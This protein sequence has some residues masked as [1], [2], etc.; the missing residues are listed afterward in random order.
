MLRT[1]LRRVRRR[2]GLTQPPPPKPEAHGPRER[3]ES[4]PRLRDAPRR[5]RPARRAGARAPRT[6]S[7]SVPRS[8]ARPGGSDS[9]SSIP[10]S[11]SHPSSARSCTSST[12]SGGRGPTTELIALV[13]PLLPA[14]RGHAHRRE[15]ARSTCPAHGRRRWSRWPHPRRARSSC[16][17]TRSSATSPV[18]ATRTAAASIDE[19]EVEGERRA[20]GD[21]MRVVTDAIARG[22]YATQIEWLA[23]GVPA[24]AAAHPPVRALRERRRR[25]A[26]TYVRVPGPRA[27]STAGRGAGAASQHGQA[28]EARRP[29]PAPRSAA[30]LLPTGGRTAARPDDGPRPVAL[31]ELRRPGLTAG[32]PG[33]RTGPDRRVRP[34]RCDATESRLL[35]DVGAVRD[36]TAEE[37]QC[38]DREDGDECQDERVLG[39]C[40]TL[41]ATDRWF[42]RRCGRGH[43]DASPPFAADGWR[44]SG[45]GR[46][47]RIPQAESA[48][49]RW[50]RMA[51]GTRD[52]GA[53]DPAHHTV[54]PERSGPAR[55]GWCRR[56]QPR[57]VDA[58]RGP[59]RSSRGSR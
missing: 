19:A 9:S 53:H 4:A 47:G 22:Q 23:R 8:R 6:S 29:G 46:S 49:R 13:P 30:A 2:L 31:A 35:L 58:A 17:A 40:L 48:I 38:Q 59:G 27:A 51:L 28:R 36:R 26:L 21:R 15:D 10:T 41:G 12:V 1:R 18:S 14:P 44:V 43:R 11:C 42:D 52:Q 3:H 20:F 33:A 54:R 50:G 39:E 32:R 5:A 56:P 34:R 24:R 55:V 45:V 57:R 7:S 16:C 25:P 37:E